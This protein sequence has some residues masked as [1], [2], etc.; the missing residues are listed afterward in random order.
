MGYSDP[1]HL[2]LCLN[3]TSKAADYVDENVSDPPTVLQLRTL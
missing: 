1:V 3:L 2:W